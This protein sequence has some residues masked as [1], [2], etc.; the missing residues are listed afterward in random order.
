MTYCRLNPRIFFNHNQEM[1]CVLI[2]EY[3][4]VKHPKECHFQSFTSHVIE[5]NADFL[6]LVLHF[7]QFRRSLELKL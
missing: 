2:C 1:F 5:L 3:F 4:Y 7:Y 6:L